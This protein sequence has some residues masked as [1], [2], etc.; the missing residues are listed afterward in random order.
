MRRSMTLKMLLY[1]GDDVLPYHWSILRA[2]DPLKPHPS[3]TLTRWID[4]G[5]SP[6]QADMLFSR[7]ERV[8]GYGP[9]NASLLWWWF[10]AITLELFEGHR[11]SLTTSKSISTCPGGC[12]LT[13]RC[14]IVGCKSSCGAHRGRFASGCH[15][16]VCFLLAGSSNWS[17]GKQT[18]KCQTYS[19]VCMMV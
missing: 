10:R 11:H 9:Q 12:T 8:Y 16:C 4:R 3:P 15:G 7:Y 1:Y 17:Q 13:I 6:E 5:Q 14:V 19:T 18:A 2:I